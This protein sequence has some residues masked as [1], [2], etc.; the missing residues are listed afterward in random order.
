[1]KNVLI[2]IIIVIFLVCMPTSGTNS[3][4]DS[5]PPMLPEKSIP[6]IEH[7]EVTD[8]TLT[9]YSKTGATEID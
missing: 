5:Y 6:G 9:V 2:K 8:N 3:K 7:I 1:M 4:T